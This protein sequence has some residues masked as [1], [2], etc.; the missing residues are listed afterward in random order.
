[1]G[2]GSDNGKD[3][4]IIKNSWGT[5]WGEEGFIKLAR[6]NDETGAGECG[7]KLAASYPTDI[8][9]FAVKA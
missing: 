6:R 5:E 2:Y 9:K 4:W 1:M 3:Y 8:E 7:I